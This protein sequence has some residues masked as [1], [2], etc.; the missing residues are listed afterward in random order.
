MKIAFVAYHFR[1]SGYVGSHRSRALAKLLEERGNDLAYMTRDTLGTWAAKSFLIW[2]LSCFWNL[3]RT[4]AEKV[5]VSCGP[6]WHLP[7]IWLACTLFSRKLICDFRDTWSFLYPLYRSEGIGRNVID[8]IKRRTA[9]LIEK[10][11]YRSCERFWVTSPGT[12]EL[13]AGLFK[14]DSKLDLVLNGYDFDPDE[15]DVQSDD[16]ETV[17]I[18]CLG[19]FAGYGIE[20]AKAALES[21]RRAALVHPGIS[22]EFIGAEPETQVLIREMGFED[23]TAFYPRMP[24]KDAIAL[25]ARADMGLLLFRDEQAQLVAKAYDYIG[26]GLTIFDCLEADSNARRFLAP[27]L[28]ADLVKKSA[29]TNYPERR[30]YSRRERL[31]EHVG[32][33][34]EKD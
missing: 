3:A 25:A 15:L 5:Y 18:V 6:Y 13:Y 17:R 21:V 26:L 27:F 29:H 7:F 22:L 1:E 8:E 9:Q 19:T 11:V 23:R 4:D 24:Y 2:C 14:D 33:I 16:S 31:K 32:K 20:R 10:Q 34:D 12:Y 28:S 30:C